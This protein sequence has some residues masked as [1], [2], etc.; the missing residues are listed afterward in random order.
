M[1]R[2]LALVVAAAGLFVGAQRGI[3]GATCPVTSACSST[4]PLIGA[5]C[6]GTTCTLDGT[7]TVSGRVCELDFGAR[8]VLLTGQLIVGS[9][10]LTIHAGGFRV[11]GT[12]SANGSPGGNVII[13]HSAGGRL[14]TFSL[15]G[16]GKIDV[17]G[18]GTGGGTLTV[19]AD[20][21]VS[22]T[23][24]Q[25]STVVAN[26]IGS[27][28]TAGTISISSS[29]GPIGVGIPVAAVG[30][31][32]GAGGSVTIDAGTNLSFTPDGS[33]VVDGGSGDAGFIELDATG[34][35]TLPNG[36]RVQG[37]G[38]GSTEGGGGEITIS[39]GSIDA[40]GVIE[41]RG[42]TSASGTVGGAGGSGGSIN[43]EATS[44]ALSMTRGAGVGL[45]ADGA[46]GGD[47][48]DIT[49]AAD[50]PTH[51]TVTIGAQ[52]SAQGFGTTGRPA[53]GGSVDVTAG[54]TLTVS[55]LIN[56]GAPAG[57]AGT[58]DLSTDRGD[59]VLGA[60]LNGIAP[61]GGG[62]VTVVSAHDVQVNADVLMRSTANLTQG[63]PG[64][65]IVMTAD[66]DL[67][68]AAATV[69][70]DVSA[71]SN[72]MG[73]DIEMSAGRNLTIGARSSLKANAGSV[74]GST[75]G[76]ISLTA[77]DFAQ[78]GNLTVD[79]QL[80]AS[81]TG[82]GAI[83]SSITLVGCQVRITGVIDSSGDAA[84]A[85]HVTARATDKHCSNDPAKPCTAVANCGGAG[86]FCDAPIAVR[87]T[88]K[89]KTTGSNTAVLPVGATPPNGNGPVMPAFGACPCDSGPPSNS[90]CAKPACV[91]SNDA[92]GCLA[93]CPLC[94]NHVI[95]FPET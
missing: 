74:V 5:C 12:L 75:G 60:P 36:S 59:V 67:S 19:N 66:N 39:A 28:S 90:C 71:A 81:G 7:I 92:A 54:S 22:L 58:I 40:Q 37:D 3:A 48:G 85:N 38:L 21:D 32:E 82:T 45:S 23:G 57:D 64:G 61:S 94:G 46:L 20:G 86:T 79:G 34:M 78:A 63:G 41:T 84:S 51:G 50:S 18:S 29:G 42:G 56:V 53:S 62:A 73:G 88:G 87:G 93:P 47:S 69:T 83:G 35:L 91:G 33:V 2:R 70:L 52:L 76:T 13:M 10:T 17:S 15:E 44:G 9:N 80:D 89:L 26:G 25:G 68:V 95:E 11:S 27:G 4:A 77:G 8:Q 31:A 6:G 24:S 16:R 65:D 72:Q 14:E 55:R 30:D 1:S 49:L 43:I